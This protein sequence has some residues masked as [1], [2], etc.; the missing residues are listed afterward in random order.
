MTAGLPGAGIGGLFFVLSAYFMLVVEITRTVR[1][2]SS[3]ARWGLVLRNVGIATA[4]I[5]A[6]TVTIWLVH[7]LLFPSPSGTGDAKGSHD[8]SNALL[9]FSPVL[10]ALAVLGAVLGGAY[11]LRLVSGRR[12]ADRSG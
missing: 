11:A 4:M 8:S 5:M 10:I 2:R 12:P 9:P 1:G 7:G 6:V 3:L